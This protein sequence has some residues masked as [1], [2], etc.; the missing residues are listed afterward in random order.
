MKKLIITIIILV[1]AISCANWEDTKKD[2]ESSTEGLKRKVE[3]YT[4]DGKLIKTYKGL[5]R[6]RSAEESS[7]VSLNLINE[8][9]R[10]VMIDNAIVVIEEE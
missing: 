1:T 3:V 10:R 6:V 4:L 8:G 9:N 5:I 7:M 2:W